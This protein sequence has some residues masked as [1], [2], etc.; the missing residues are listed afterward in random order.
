M[1]KRKYDEEFTS[2]HDFYIDK[3]DSCKLGSGSFASVIL[4]RS[5]RTEMQYAI[6]TVG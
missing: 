4:A 3:D 6:K 2:L 5:V 1:Q